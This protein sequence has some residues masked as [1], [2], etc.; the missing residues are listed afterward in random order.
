[1]FF[2]KD[3]SRAEKHRRSSKDHGSTI[4]DRE[5]TRRDVFIS[6]EWSEL[7]VF[8]SSLNR[9]PNLIEL[10]LNIVVKQQILMKM[11]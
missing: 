5:G 10:N 1:M 2:L 6:K 3:D 11:Q 9:N 4:D 7:F 8:F